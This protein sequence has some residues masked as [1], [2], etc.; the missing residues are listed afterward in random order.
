MNNTITLETIEQAWK[1]Y[2]Q[3]KEHAEQ[4]EFPDLLV[5]DF[6]F[7]P[8]YNDLKENWDEHHAE[9]FLKAFATVGK[10]FGFEVP[11]VTEV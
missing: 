2:E 6:K 3:Y 7:T 9:V 10:H 5:T 1:N 8:L 4:H 11:I